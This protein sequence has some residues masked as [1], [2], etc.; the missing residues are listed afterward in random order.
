MTTR[1]TY[2]AAAA[3]ILAMP[4]AL[5]PAFGGNLN[6]L[7]N[8]PLSYFKPEDMELMRQNAMKVLED[9]S[10]TAKQSWSNPST[11]VSGLAEVRGQFKATDGATCK[12]L[13]VANKAKGLESS[14]TYTACNY[15]D[16]GWV[17]NTDATPAK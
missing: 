13:R 10:P 9:S 17:L 3:A 4:T 6:F 8:S 15:P 11:G 12:R 2:L 5:T 14:A 7:G 1:A 16:R